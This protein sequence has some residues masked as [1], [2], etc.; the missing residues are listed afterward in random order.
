MFKMKGYCGM[1]LEDDLNAKKIV[2]FLKKEYKRK[3]QDTLEKAT[4]QRADD[5]ILFYDFPIVWPKAPK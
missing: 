4:Y 2:A 1:G 5:Q 3:N